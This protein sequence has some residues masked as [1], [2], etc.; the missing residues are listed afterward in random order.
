[1]VLFPGRRFFCRRPAFDFDR[2]SFAAI[3]KRRLR[4]EYKVPV[5]FKFAATH[6]LEKELD[7]AVEAGVDYIVVE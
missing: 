3:L 5:G 1:M 4:G 6:Y 2:G 7:I